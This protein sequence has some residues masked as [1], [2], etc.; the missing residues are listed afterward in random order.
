MIRS[1]TQVAKAQPGSIGREAVQK[2]IE[3]PEIPQKGEVGNITRSL[4]EEPLERRVPV[5]SE[6]VVSAVPIP[7]TA[8][9]IGGQAASAL[10]PQVAQP[11]L[12]GGNH[13]RPATAVIGGPAPG[14]GIA[15]G[16]Q[17]LGLPEGLELK[18]PTGERITKVGQAAHVPDVGIFT[19][20][21]EVTREPEFA[22]LDIARTAKEAL[23]GT[24]G[25]TTQIKSAT[26]RGETPTRPTAGTISGRVIAGE[27]GITPSNEPLSAKEALTLYGPSAGASVGGAQLLR[28]LLSNLTTA[29][30][31]FGSRLMGGLIP[32]VEAAVPGL[33][34]QGAGL[35]LRSLSL[36]LS[37]GAGI[38]GSEI[39]RQKAGQ[40][41][42]RAMT[43]RQPI[44][45]GP[46]YLR[47]APKVSPIQQGI[48]DII[49][50][51]KYYANQ[52]TN[53]LKSLFGRK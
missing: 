38:I 19:G 14:A 11:M 45:T 26:G 44:Y 15:L 49:G 27:P 33:I 34:R 50:R 30:T 48:N 10:G 16:E 37:I 24:P 25:G 2:R 52:A 22:G 47:S 7:E 20:G 17:P 4:L 41:Y 35:G 40:E 12:A 39:G 53:F 3:K 43:A 29:A 13:P 51:T 5:G 23:K 42:A 28:S 31:Q 32:E 9:Q 6:K 36:P 21:R 1:I 8:S 18:T 46:T